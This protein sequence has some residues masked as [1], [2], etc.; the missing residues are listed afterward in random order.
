LHKNHGVYTDDGITDSFC[1]N[2]PQ[3]TL[4]RYAANP[5]P[6]VACQFICADRQG[7]L[8]IITE[9]YHCK[10]QDVR[11]AEMKRQFHRMVGSG[12]AYILLNNKSPQ[13]R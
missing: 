8:P 5:L 9:I 13:N 6:I 2:R 4:Y 1:P 3:F 12:T 10:G 11:Y 7:F